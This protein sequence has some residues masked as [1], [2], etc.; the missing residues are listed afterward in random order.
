MWRELSAFQ[1]QLFIAAISVVV[2]F[3]P[4]LIFLADLGG[5]ELVFSFLLLYYK[6]LLLKLQSTYLKIKNEAYFCIGLIRSCAAAQPKIFLTQA[7]FSCI[8]LAVTG[9]VF[10]AAVLFMPALMLNSVLI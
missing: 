6:P 9:S 2:P 8:A 4:E 7:T 10:Y 5:V 1:K 3:A